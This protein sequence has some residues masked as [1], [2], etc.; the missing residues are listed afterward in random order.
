MGVVGVVGWVW[1]GVVWGLWGWEVWE[2]CVVGGWVVS[3]IGGGMWEVRVGG[4]YR[5]ECGISLGGGGG[6]FRWIRS[7]LDNRVFEGEEENK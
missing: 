6:L 4:V 1:G 7:V 5:W 3:G 2:C